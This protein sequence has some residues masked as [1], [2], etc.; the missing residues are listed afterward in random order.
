MG[1]NETEVI[2]NDIKK[3]KYQEIAKEILRI[4]SRNTYKDQ[5]VKSDNNR[6]DEVVNEYLDLN[7]LNLKDVMAIQKFIDFY[8]SK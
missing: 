1:I 4:N 6:I 3:E 5:I 7:E 8:K 2:V